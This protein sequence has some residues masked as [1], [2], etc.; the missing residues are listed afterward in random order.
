MV[1]REIRT[2][3]M[4]LFDGPTL[5]LLATVNGHGRPWTRYVMSR[6]DG[7]M[8]LRIPTKSTTR[9]VD[10]IRRFPFVHVLVGKDLY[11]RNG[12]YAQIEG[13]AY[14]TRNTDALARFWNDGMT[15]YFSGPNDPS[16]LL[17]EIRPERIEYW[18]MMEA[19]NPHVLEEVDIIPQ[20]LPFDD[21][22]WMSEEGVTPV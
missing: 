4:D 1:A 2:R 17:I 22:Y 21:E 7:D 18:N 6:M 3:V 10:D 12:A 20:G 15:R 9:K 16:F 11:G 13:R 5:S 19:K 8:T 14:L